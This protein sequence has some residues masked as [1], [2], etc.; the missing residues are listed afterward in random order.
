LRRSVDLIN[1]TLRGTKTL[2][3]FE[4]ARVDPERSIEETVKE[5]AKLIKEGKF[6]HLGLSEC[7]AETLKRAN[8]VH[9][10]AMEIEISPWSYE[11]EAKK[12]IATAKELGVTV[13]GYSPLGRGFLTGQIRSINDLPEGDFRRRL[14]RFQGD[15]IIKHN[16][17]LVDLLKSIGEKK[18]ATPGQISIAWVSHLGKNVIPLPGSSKANR[19][20]E[21]LAGGDIDLTEEDLQEINKGIETIDVKGDRYYGLSDKEM[22]LWG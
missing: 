19:T 18:N 4:C 22:H 16:L 9:P 21:N 7:S 20:L 17:Q 1:E 13:V 15:E 12:V 10:I 8:A 14:T 6:T 11:E 5:L 3:L 2:D